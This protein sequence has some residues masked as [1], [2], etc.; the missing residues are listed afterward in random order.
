VTLKGCID[1]D[2]TGYKAFACFTYNYLF[3]VVYGLISW[4]SKRALIVTLFTLEAEFTGLIK[5]IREAF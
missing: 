4:K 2:F 5:G 1:S 3:K